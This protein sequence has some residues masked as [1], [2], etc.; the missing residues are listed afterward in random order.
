MRLVFDTNVY[1][2][3]T[4]T[5]GYMQEQLCKAEPS[6]AYEIFI[7]PAIILEIQQKL[8]TTFRKDNAEA[9]AFIRLVLQY[10]T[11]V[12]PARHITG[13]LRDT[14]DHIILECA[15]EAKAE[16][17]VTADRELLPL[18]N[19]EGIAIIHPT[20]LQYY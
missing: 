16:A 19:Y 7:S 12:Y 4:K 2:A 8:V 11:E 13:V 15:L 14:D 1:L 10:V 3:A 18:K 20:M 17:I 9:T 6:G 5:G